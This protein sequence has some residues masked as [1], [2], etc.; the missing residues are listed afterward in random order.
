M[1]LLKGEK[2]SFNRWKQLQKRPMGLDDN[3][4]MFWDLLV[5]ISLTR[6]YNANF[7]TNKHTHTLHFYVV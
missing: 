5:V 1:V 6:D 4:R 7:P 2:W 3:F